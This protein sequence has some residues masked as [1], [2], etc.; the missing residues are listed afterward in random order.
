[1][2]TT[3]ISKACQ[4]YTSNQDFTQILQQVIHN[5]KHYIVPI[6][7]NTTHLRVIIPALS[8]QAAYQ[9]AKEEFEPDDWTVNPDYQ[10]Y[11]TI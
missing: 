6:S 3:P 9:L 11:K 7:R 8:P 5:T 1:M 2:K 4:I 10:N